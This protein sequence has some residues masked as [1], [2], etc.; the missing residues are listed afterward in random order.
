MYLWRNILHPR[1]TLSPPSPDPRRTSEQNK[2]EK[3]TP[4]FKDIPRYI[5]SATGTF[6]IQLQLVA[7]N[8]GD[9]NK[10]P[11]ND[12][13]AAQHGDL[14]TLSSTS[15]AKRHIH[16][17]S[18]RTMKLRS[19]VLQIHFGNRH[20]QR[21]ARGKNNSSVYVNITD[22]RRLYLQE[23]YVMANKERK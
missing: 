1:V 22:S 16:R 7:F 2:D 17:G 21:N 9:W 14:I 13:L 6:G 4:L 20:M 8:L 19:S 5:L 18:Y 23:R 15:E 11:I 3:H 10:P 12:T